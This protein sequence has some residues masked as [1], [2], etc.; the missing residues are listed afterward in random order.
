MTSR[1]KRLDKLIQHRARELDKRIAALAAVRT[2]ERA[3]EAKAEGER[4]AL[5]RAEQARRDAISG[6]LDA[7]G[8]MD[9]SDF[10]VSCGRRRELAEGLLLRARRA[11]QKAQGDVQAAKN[12]LKKI[13]LLTQ[14]L[15]TEQRAQEARV[16]Q[17]ATDELVTLRHGDLKRR[18]AP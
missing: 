16:E 14:R 18:S 12:D 8:F 3:A 11:V 7:Q 10:L 17:R 1:K 6:P 2:Q 15:A 5:R 4:D 13:E 9:A